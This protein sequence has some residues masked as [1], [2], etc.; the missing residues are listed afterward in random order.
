M[1]NNKVEIGEDYPLVC[2]RCLGPDAYVRMTKV[3]NGVEC[4]I[5]KRPATLFEWRTS[6]GIKRSTCVAYDVAAQKNICQVCMSDLTFGLPVGVR[7]TFL[8]TAL[9]RGIEGIS[10]TFATQPKSRVGQDYLLNQQL[11]LRGNDDEKQ[12]QLQDEASTLA[13]SSLV[14]GA[15]AHMDMKQPAAGKFQLPPIC[16]KWLQT[17]APCANQC[18]KRPCC[19]A[20]KFP[21]LTQQKMRD[22]VEDDLKHARPVEKLALDLLTRLTASSEPKKQK[23]HTTYTL[24]VSNLPRNVTEMQVRQAFDKFQGVVGNNIRLANLVAFVEFDSKANAE[25]VLSL[26]VI[27]I[28]DSMAK[29]AWAKSTSAQEQEEESSNNKKKPR[30]QQEE[31]TPVVAAARPQAL[32]SAIALRKSK[33]LDFDL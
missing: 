23:Q 22:R 20:F 14:A 29:L 13:V 5:S 33:G 4:K 11:A 26:N 18:S 12:L 17:N 7:D 30:V 19:G 21:E 10:Q 25:L 27:K 24:Y 15:Q 8:R 31:A 32:L 28:G 1:N 2:E 9:E 16:P 3:S 6:N